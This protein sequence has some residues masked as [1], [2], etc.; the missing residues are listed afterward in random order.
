MKDLWLEIRVCS[1]WSTIQ[2]FSYCFMFILFRKYLDCKLFQP[3]GA[4]KYELW[5]KCVGHDTFSQKVCKL[6][7]LF[8]KDALHANKTS[9]DE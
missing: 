6:F 8:S 3:N 4:S 7:C 5:M 9:A 1:L 2:L